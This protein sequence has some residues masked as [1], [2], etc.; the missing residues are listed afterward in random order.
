MHL[1]CLG[2]AAGHHLTL[3]YVSSMDMVSNRAYTEAE[4]ERGDARR[5]RGTFAAAEP[6]QAQGERMCHEMRR[7]LL[8]LVASRG[9]RAGQQGR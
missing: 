9:H 2:P 5:A 8:I 4:L 6:T 1:A 3:R 7:I